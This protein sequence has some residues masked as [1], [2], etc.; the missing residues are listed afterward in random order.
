MFKNILQLITGNGLAQLIQFLSIPIL[1]KFYSPESFGHLALA[2]AISGMLGVL[3]S[4]QLHVGIVSLKSRLTVNRLIP[5]GV[6]LNLLMTLVSFFIMLLVDFIFYEKALD[7]HFILLVVGITFF[8]STNN[9]FRGYFVYLGDFSVISKLLIIRSLIIVILQFSFVIKLIDYGLILALLIGELV[10]FFIILLFKLRLQSFHYNKP[11]RI[12]C[13]LCFF[14][15]K[16]KDFVVYGTFQELVSVAIFWMPLVGI[17]FVFGTDASGQYSVGARILWPLTILITSSVAQVLY[18]RMANATSS[19]MSEQILFKAS[20]KLIFI[21]IM[22]CAYIITPLIFTLILSDEWDAAATLSS[23][24]ATMCVI[25]LYVL[26]YRVLFRVFKKQRVL[27]MI[28]GGYL[29]I[30]SLAVTLFDFKEVKSLLEVFI[31]LGVLQ[32][33]FI[34]LISRRFLMASNPMT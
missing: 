14:L 22:C 9:L 28:E 6:F 16:L 34:E 19:E 5:C 20:V 33:I 15:K 8:S 26:P 11:L 24:V 12:C 21:P 30:L 2:I 10:L 31:V 7:I 32:A 23:Y 13:E 27:L 4:L 1:T 3:S 18:H 29:L 17:T 25:F